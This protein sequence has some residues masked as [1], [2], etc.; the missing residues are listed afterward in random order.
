MPKD[1]FSDAKG[2]N[3]FEDPAIAQEWIS[4]VETFSVGREQYVK[5][6]L[7]TWLSD[8]NIHRVMDLGAGEGVAVPLCTGKKYV[9]IEPS[10]DLVQRA[11]QKYGGSAE[12]I[13]GNIYNIPVMSEQFDGA[14]SANVW[15]HLQSI[16]RASKELSRILVPQGKFLI[17]NPNPKAYPAWEKYYS[18]VKKEG[19]RMEGSVKTGS[20]SLSKNIFYQHSEEEITEALIASGLEIDASATM[21]PDPKGSI[22]LLKYYSG[23]KR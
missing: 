14:F 2:D 19:K 23:H 15:F 8:P 13:K 6:T 18:D 17:I 16:D 20:I 22:D 7:V 3:P 11:K 9:G 4:S 10:E 12:F 1:Y 5:P 21:Y